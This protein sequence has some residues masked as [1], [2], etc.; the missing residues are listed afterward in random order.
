MTSKIPTFIKGSF[1]LKGLVLL[2]G[3]AGNWNP[4][5]VPKKDYPY[6]IT[7]KPQV[8]KKIQVPAGTKLVYEEQFLKKGKQA[9]SLSEE[10]LT[11]IELPEGETLEW[12][13]VPVNSI[14]KFYNQQMKGF[15]LYPNFEKGNNPGKTKFFQLWESYGCDLGISVKNTN[16]WS[17]NTHNISDV[18]SCG[19]SYQRYFKE[20]ANQQAVLNKLYS[21]LMKVGT[22]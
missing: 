1:L 15:T 3:C 22:N 6:F 7:T 8:V 21:E 14:R 16:D 13:G 10:K 11:S 20:D 2:S 17:F 5:H 9:K 4:N 18:Q 12:A 19:V